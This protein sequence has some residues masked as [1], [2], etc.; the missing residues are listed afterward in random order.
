MLF[1]GTP[2]SCHPSRLAQF[3]GRRP[4]KRDE[5]GSPGLWPGQPLTKVGFVLGVPLA[6]S[7]PDFSKISVSAS[8]GLIP[9]SFSL[10]LA[11]VYTTLPSNATSKR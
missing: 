11:L 6:C 7:S 3:N 9:H 8:N 2:T 1:P 4:G 10:A 5:R